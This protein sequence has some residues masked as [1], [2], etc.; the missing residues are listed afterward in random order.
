MSVSGRMLILDTVIEENKSWQDAFQPDVLQKLLIQAVSS[1]GSAKNVSSNGKGSSSD[2]PIKPYLGPE[3]PQQ[4]VK[5]V[6]GTLDPA[7]TCNY[8][9][10]KG[11]YVRSC[12]RLKRKK[13]REQTAKTSS[14]AV[15]SE[16]SSPN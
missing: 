3:R 6:D 14:A 11:H 1:S 13:E 9:K 4:M 5:G 7:I 8:C 12:P 15:S 16:S 10:D 2:N